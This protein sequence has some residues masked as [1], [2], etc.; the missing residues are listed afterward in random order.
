M[1]R[2]LSRGTSTIS[3]RRILALA[4]LPAVA[5]MLAAPAWAEKPSWNEDSGER[6]VNVKIKVMADDGGEMTELD[7]SDLEVGETRWITS[8]SG[9]DIGITREADGYRLD[10]DGEETFIATPGDGAHNRVM[11]RAIGHGDGEGLHEAMQNVWVTGD[12]QVIHLDGESLDTVFISGLGD[13]DEYQK[14]DI[15]DALRAAGV[16]KEVHFSPAGGGAHSFMFMTSGG[17]LHADG[18]TTVDVEVIKKCLPGDG[19]GNII[20]IEKKK[21]TSDDD[22]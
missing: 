21:F 22:N 4:V 13:L 9:K 2:F 12:Q 7:L 5:L 14:A 3:L 16:D 15:I 17:D 1:V 8:D 20:I 19:D 6:H 18:E 11:V 10:I